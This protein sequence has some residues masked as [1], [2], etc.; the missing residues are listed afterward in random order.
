MAAINDR[1]LVYMIEYKCENLLNIV[2][3]Q[4]TFRGFECQKWG[5]K[6]CTLFRVMDLFF[7]NVGTKLLLKSTYE[8]HQSFNFFT[9]IP[10]QIFIKKSILILKVCMLSQ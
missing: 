7:P 1:Q 4:S 9:P 3:L 8:S 6:F 5:E 2:S 10:Y